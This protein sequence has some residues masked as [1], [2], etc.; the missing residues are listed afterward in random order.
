MT[1]A[2]PAPGD[3]QVL[4]RDQ[5]ADIRARADA[6][7]ADLAARLGPAADP[8]RIGA[9]LQAGAAKGAALVAAIEGL[10]RPA[11]EELI[12]LV[13]CG[14]GEYSFTEARAYSQATSDKGTA[15]YLAKKAPVLSELLKTALATLD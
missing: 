14:M 10:S 3:L 15:Q 12:A 1:A 5:V 9:D 11:R 2:A 4:T 13:W 6:Y 7:A 8:D